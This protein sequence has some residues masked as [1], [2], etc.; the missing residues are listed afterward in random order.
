MEAE[1]ACICVVLRAFTD[2]DVCSFGIAADV[3][4]Y[5]NINPANWAI[6]ACCVEQDA[7]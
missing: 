7:W 6:G 1:A 3:E 5:C 4:Y 2:I